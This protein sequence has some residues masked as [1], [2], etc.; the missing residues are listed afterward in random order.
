MERNALDRNATHAFSLLVQLCM[1][2][3]ASLANPLC[4]P[5]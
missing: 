5:S 4:Q 2:V 1:L 3:T